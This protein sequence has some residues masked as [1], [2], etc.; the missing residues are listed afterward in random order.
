MRRKTTLAIALGAVVVS[1]GAGWVAGRQVRSP[2]EVAAR[3]A[4]PKAS[5][6]AVPVERTRLQ[7]EV[8][9]RGTVGYGSPQV[10]SL[11]ASA[12]KKGTAVVTRPPEKGAS[13]GEGS[14][15]M[16]ASG[17]PVLVLQGAV[18]AYRDLGPGAS[19]E[20]VRQLEAGLVRLGFDPGPVDGTYDSQTAAAVGAWYAASGWT[21]LGPTDEQL[22]A[23][24]AAQADLSG[25]QESLL[26]A[27]EGLS[28]AQGAL[29]TANERVRAAHAAAEAAPAAEA[30]D[31]A[32]AQRERLAAVAE[33]ANRTAAL[34]AA[35]DAQTVANLRFGEAQRDPSK[36]PSP[37]ELASLQVAA[38]QASAAVG[39]ARADL[40]AAQAAQA[41]LVPPPRPGTAQAAAVKDTA[42]AVN[43]AARAADAV[44]LAQRRVALVAAR[45]GASPVA[46]LGGRL[47]VQVPADELLFFASLPVRV[48]ETK[49]KVGEALSGPVMTVTNSQLVVSGA[50]TL[51]DARVVRRGAVVAISDRDLGARASGTVSEVADAPGTRGVEP[52]RFYVGV[53]P[54]DAPPSLVGAS[55]VL[56]I[57]VQA[58]DAEVLAV[59]V[60]A[61]S[62]AA[63]GTSRVQVE[64]PDRTTRFVT[65]RPG[66][67]AKG[68][69]EVT[70]VGG[71]LAPG[72]LVVVGA[73]PGV[74]GPTGGAAPATTTAI[75]TTTTATTTTA[76]STTTR[77]ASRAS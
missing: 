67:A 38:R 24:R 2:A 62:V 5:L 45:A 74:A 42:A 53:T 17:R 29:A 6:I 33:V 52:Q 20:D 44:Q 31:Q 41:A 58:T 7:S 10:V 47:G 71:A 51:D 75:A 1:A 16:A 14:V 28:A 43:E 34:Q 26:G 61:L 50:L 46:E 63:D 12:L 55:V 18:P 3:T 9:T 15:A 27:Q 60:S 70:P 11:P 30:A 19:G 21:P 36:A 77:G 8:I 39:V 22:Q 57:T 25:A 69:V 32:R 13:L 68:L 72:E 56:T 35:V 64:A 54:T 49:V 76:T 48:D 65:V 4:P 73:G 40:A 59:P 23:L 66:L 37:S